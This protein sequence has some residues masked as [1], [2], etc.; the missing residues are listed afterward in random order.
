M[1]G[2]VY[3]IQAVGHENNTVFVYS[4]NELQLITHVDGILNARLGYLIKLSE[5]RW[6]GKLF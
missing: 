4:P 1:N 6:K 5:M 3:A 2:A